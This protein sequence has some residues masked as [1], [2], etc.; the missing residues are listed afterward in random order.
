MT[1]IHP[2]VSDEKVSIVVRR[3]LSYIYIQYTV[4]F[5]YAL[6]VNRSWERET[7][8]TS[9]YVFNYSTTTHYNHTRLLFPFDCISYKYKR[10]SQK[11]SRSCDV[12]FLAFSSFAR[13]RLIQIENGVIKELLVEGITIIIFGRTPHSKFK[14][15][16]K[17]TNYLEFTKQ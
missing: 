15:Q 2:I 3:E 6:S 10:C 13:L 17:I 5:G 14:N 11:L 7:W 12:S 1:L 9:D 16:N 8:D 4:Y